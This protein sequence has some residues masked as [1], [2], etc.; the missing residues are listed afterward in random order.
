MTECR[1][2]HPLAA[3][4]PEPNIIK[5]RSSSGD[6]NINRVL[7]TCLALGLLGGLAAA[8]GVAMVA[9]LLLANSHM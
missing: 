1:A 8:T 4:N 5:R 2:F 9:S 3:A 6:R 7:M